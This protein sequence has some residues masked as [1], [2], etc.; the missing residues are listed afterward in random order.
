LQS[1]T[2][3]YYRVMTIRQTLIILIIAVVSF[4]ATLSLADERIWLKAKINGK[5]VH[6]CFDSGSNL[7]A[8]CPQTMQRLGLKF[9]PAPTN[10]LWHYVLAGDT[11]D[12]TLTL[13]GMDGKMSFVVLDLPAYVYA[14]ADFDGLI[15]WYVVSH[16][17]LRIDAVEREMTALPKVPKQT[18]Q[19]AQLTVLTNFGALDLQIPHGDRTNGVL[20]IDT[21][22]DSGLALPAQEWRRWKEAHPQSP[23]TIN[24]DFTPSDGFFLTE[25]AWADQISVGPVV[26]TG[27]PIRCAGPAGATR[28]GAQYEG[29]LGLAALK[30]L[31]LIVDGNNGLAYLRAKKTRPPAYP[32]NRLGAIFAVTTT[33]T[34]QAVARVVDGGPA[35]EAGVRDGDV[36]LQVDEVTVKGWT[37]DWLSRFYMPAGTKLKLTLQRDGKIFTTTATLREIL[38]PSPNKNK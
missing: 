3:I 29:T 25:E 12:C 7:A 31:D 35:Y 1:V 13:D 34:N 30:R 28:W 37:D 10:A 24:T 2:K 21:G 22:S 32:H 18:T 9:I 36:L 11:E 4:R 27:V 8:L 15:G 19:W 17:V 33:Q 26:L 16:N 20:C 23:I 38:R 6:L 5:P 14:G